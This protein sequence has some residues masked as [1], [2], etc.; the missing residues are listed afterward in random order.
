MRRAVTLAVLLVVCCR[1]AEDPKRDE[2]LR[3]HLT[4]MRK[5]IADYRA[6]KQRGPRSL[7]DLVETKFLHAIPN[8]PITQRADWREITEQ[9][10]V[11]SDDFAQGSS[12]PPD[13]ELVDVRSR[14]PGKD[15]AGKPYAEY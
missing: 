13:V 14:A 2:T 10:V 7:Q 6:D 1:P 3:Q 11:Q 15:R 8:D 5:A 9:V 4:E 12:A